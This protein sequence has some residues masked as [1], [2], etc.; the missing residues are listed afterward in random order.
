MPR[1]LQGLRS[2]LLH[3]H[4]W[5]ASC[6]WIAAS[7]RSQVAT[8]PELWAGVL[9]QG[10]ITVS[11]ASNPLNSLAITSQAPALIQALWEM[12]GTDTNGLSTCWVKE[13]MVK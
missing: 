4:F 10:S 11:G 13:L 1:L 8:A 3:P 12:L 9:L 5:K 7:P 6:R 2:P